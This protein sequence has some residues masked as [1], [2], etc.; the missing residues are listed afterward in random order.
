MHNSSFY[1]KKYR[2]DPLF[3]VVQALFIT[4]RNKKTEENCVNLKRNLNRL[5]DVG[6]I[7]GVKPQSHI[8]GFGP[9]RATVHP[10]LSNRGASA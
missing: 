7:R 9:G 2:P 6:Q 5:Y 4:H 3:L 8:H 10:D 1:M